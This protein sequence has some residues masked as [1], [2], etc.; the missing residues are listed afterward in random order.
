MDHDRWPRETFEDRFAIL[1]SIMLRAL[2]RRRV[3]AQR[4]AA[5]RGVRFLL[6]S[7]A[8]GAYAELCGVRYEV[9]EAHVAFYR[10]LG[11]DLAAR[12]GGAG[13]SLPLPATYV[14]GRDGV[15]AYRFIDPGWSYRAEPAA[16]VEAV[17]ALTK[18]RRGTERA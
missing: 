4:T 12:H 16:L 14:V 13:W 15:I 8:E 7:D 2:E 5:A 17:E 10:R 18:A 9:P 1:A 3:R 6:L 11:V